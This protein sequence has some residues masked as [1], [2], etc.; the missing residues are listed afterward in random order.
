M[1]KRDD[2]KKEIKRQDEEVYG[3]ETMAGSSPDPESDDDVAETYKKVIGH[4][5]KKGESLA[6]EVDEAERSRRGQP[7]HEHKKRNRKT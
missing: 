3:E 1:T 7:A 4:E 6:D 5:P 2:I